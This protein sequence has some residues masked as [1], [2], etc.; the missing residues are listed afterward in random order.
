[1]PTGTQPTRRSTVGIPDLGSHNFAPV[2]RCLPGDWTERYGTRS[3]LIET[4]VETPC[5]T[6]AVYRASGRIH[7]RTQGRGRHDRVR[8]CDKPGKDV[9]LWPLRRDW[10]RTLNR[11]NQ[12]DQHGSTES[13]VEIRKYEPHGQ[14]DWLR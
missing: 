12:L 3:V 2:R 1:M 14:S 9:W 13:S 5:Y 4:F 6:G 10:K 11:W 8:L 7:V